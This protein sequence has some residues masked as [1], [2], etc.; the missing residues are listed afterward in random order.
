MILVT[1][2]TGLT[3][4]HL[5]FELTKAGRAV[6][7][8]KRAN[9]SVDFV[10]N[11][12]SLYASNADELLKLIEWVDVDLLDFSAIS[13][14][15]NGVE[16]VYHTG[17]V[18]SFNP[19]DSQSI[20]ETNI[21]GTANIVDA[22][23]QRGVKTLCHISS[24]ASLGEPNEQG[25]VD[26]S[27]IWSKIKGKSA[28]AKSKFYGEMEVWRG[29]EQGLRVIIVNPSVILG[30][31]RW[32]SGSGQL[33]TRLSKGMPFY[34]NGVTGYVDVRDVARAM[35]LLNENQVVKNERFILNSQNLTYKEVFS[36]IALSAGKKEPRYEV[37]PWM[38]NVVYPIVKLFGTLIGKGATISR[39]NLNSAF[40]KTFYSSEKIKAQ[41]SFSFI[42]IS[43]SV[44]FIS[45]IYQKKSI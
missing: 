43:D 14:S 16:T 19:K 27:C 25:I 22:C 15:I 35:V 23:I 3:G 5:L 24:I 41:I 32:N 13:E 28:Y 31:G 38:I 21:R 11:I 17:A 20:S 37:K 44:K 4:S 10:K 2:G 39:E 1:G 9:S 34:T 6:R 36:T 26:E 18:V 45:E 8:T 42:P 12:F 33:F 29:A 30:P 40:S 7:A